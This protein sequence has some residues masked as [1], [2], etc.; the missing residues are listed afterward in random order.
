MPRS[1]TYGIPLVITANT[2]GAK[3]ADK[4]LKSLIKNTKSFGLTSKLSI[5]A[6]SV[7]LAAYTKKS[8]AAALA[9]EKA[10]K[11]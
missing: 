10:Q 8:I 2:A 7:A 3:K 1:S 5:G 4:S 11:A 9:D 6:A